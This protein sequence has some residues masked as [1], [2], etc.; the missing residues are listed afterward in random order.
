MAS[1]RDA[2]IKLLEQQN[3]ALLEQVASLTRQVENLTE[4]I[5]QMRRDK[6]GSS[7]EKTPREDIGDQMYLEQVF[8]EVEVS[9]DE[10]IPEPCKITAQGK[11]RAKSKGSRKEVLLKDIPVK[12]IICK[13]TESSLVCPSCHGSLKPIGQTLVRQEIEYIPASLQ[14]VKYVQESYECPKC[15]HTDHPYIA[16]AF[17]P[18][19]LLNHS[20][21][22]ASS[23]AAVI[24]NKYVNAQP[25]YRQEKDWQR[26]GIDLSR[27]TMANW[28]IRCS[29]DYF[30]P[31]FEKMR[32]ELIAR[33]IVHCDETPV[34][35][36]KEDGKKPQTKSYMWL[37]RTGSDG[38]YP[39]VLY[40]YKPSRSGENATNFLKDFKGYVHSDGYSG[41]GKLK[42]IERC[43]CWAHLRRKFVEAIPDKKSGNGLTN[44]ELGRA[45][46]DRL[47]AIEKD[48]KDL[49]PEDRY[50]K[51]LEL[52]KPVLGEFWAWL[53]KLN[54]L[55]GSAL[56][57][58]KTYAVNQKSFMEN[59][60]H[61]GRL[62]ISNNAAENAIRPF[63]VG[64]KNWLFADTS[65][66]AAASAIIYSL[67]ETAKANGLDTYKYLEYVLKNMPDSD[68]MR[69]P[70][71]L[72]TLMPWAE[73]AKA[74]CC[75]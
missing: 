22:S 48:L 12:E 46:C 16:K 41:Y 13:G 24:Y 54:P 73:A 52:E 63:T 49:S 31:L 43:G 67:V 40:D 2:Y 74:A 9:T 75:E 3:K 26:L 59:Y 69:H 65:K 36:L 44:A 4:M 51:R 55:P 56:G 6:F 27:A 66:G 38:K 71:N 57:R 19:S 64:R 42:N 50:I 15:K 18:K 37:Y 53:D 34:Q 14:I 8:N 29:E 61:D 1:D 39:I 62:E 20:L 30:Q 72:E 28:V 25:L 11:I 7:S 70:E 35:V 58:A 17:V 33:D 10:S 32:T 5:L 23:V 21:A 45:Y 47:F 68:W 60:L